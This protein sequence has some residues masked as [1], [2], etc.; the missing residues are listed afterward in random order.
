MDSLPTIGMYIV[1]EGRYHTCTKQVHEVYL[2]LSGK[3][4]FA[5][6]AIELGRSRWPFSHLHNSGLVF[7]PNKYLIL[8]AKH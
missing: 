4:P 8:S 6:D 5:E 2:D 7:P 1:L 3:R